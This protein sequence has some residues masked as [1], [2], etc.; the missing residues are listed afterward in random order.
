MQF[1]ILSSLSALALFV[2]SLALLALGRQIGERRLKA[3]PAG[4]SAGHG[5]VEA[6]V[7]GLL[8]LLL[9]FSFSGALQR[10]EDRRQLIA[11][12][13]TA[14]A[15]AYWQA[16]LLQPSARAQ[17]RD[18]L[19][20]YVQVRLEASRQPRLIEGG[21]EVMASD[22]VKRGEA[23]QRQI[24]QM[25]TDPNHAQRAESV[26]QVLL[27]TLTNMFAV[28]KARNLVGQRHPPE[29]IFVM[30]F[31]LTLVGA[32]LA[33]YGMAAN[34]TPSWTHMVGFALSLAAT[35]F[36]ISDV[37][38]PRSGLIRVDKFDQVLINALGST[39]D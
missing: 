31:G 30:L 28:A 29:I 3:D 38:Y 24:W 19:R 7:F 39:P 6:A 4:G 26:E 32:L 37:E 9:A 17:L 22:I 23:L 15:T 1:V 36:V 5:A 16:E 35:V 14:I 11:D 12:E 18:K 25:A 20:Q 13:A 33:G 8:G 34:K 27:P 2:A 21:Q 10:F